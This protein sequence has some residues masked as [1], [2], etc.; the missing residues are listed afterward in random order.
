VGSWAAVADSAGVA[1]GV[2]A[3]AVEAVA[4]GAA[5]AA[6]GAARRRAALGANFLPVVFSGGES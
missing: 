4:E 3:G 6:A 5:G 2:G 1:D